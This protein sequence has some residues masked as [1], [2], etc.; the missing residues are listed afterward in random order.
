MINAP[1][2]PRKTSRSVRVGPEDHG[3]RMSLDKF[4]RAIGRE[5]YLYELSKGVIEVVNVPH[6]SHG[7][8]IQ[9]IRNQL[10]VFQE[11]NPGLIELVA[12]GSDAKILLDSEQSERHPDISIYLTPAPDTRDVWSLWVPAIVVEVVSPSSTRRDYEEKPDEYLAFGVDEYWIVDAARRQMTAL[13]RWRGKWKPKV[14]R[15]TQKYTTR[16]LPAFSLDL[17]RVFAAAQ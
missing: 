16:H 3:R 15:P 9:A 7:K 4:D 14:L 8:Q 13:L 12:G 17:K 2:A 1:S 11:L 6:P 5:G 10:V